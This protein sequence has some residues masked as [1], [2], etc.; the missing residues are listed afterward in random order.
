ML[1]T[2]LQK[3]LLFMFPPFTEGACFQAFLTSKREIDM[4]PV[5]LAKFFPDA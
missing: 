1:P 4:K 2:A 5:M 3:S